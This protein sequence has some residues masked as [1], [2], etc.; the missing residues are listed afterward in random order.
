VPRLFSES[1]RANL[2]L[3]RRDDPVVLDAAIR[4]AVLDPDVPALERGLDTLIGPRG[5]KL[6]GGQ[7]QRAAAARMFVS[8]AELL[9]FDDLSSAL[10][11]ETEAELWSRLF[12]RDD[13]VTCLV[14]SHRPVALRRA[15]QILLMEDGRLV[16]RGTLTEL[17]E[18]SEEMRRL[19]QHEH[20]SARRPASATGNRAP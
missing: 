14:V 8:G 15:D 19:W 11:A 13:E 18:T 12:A 1:L 9:V 20:G 3:G 2:L 4:A 17:L 10:D 7:V 16:A 6:S 5:V